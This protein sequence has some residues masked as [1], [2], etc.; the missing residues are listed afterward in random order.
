MERRRL[1]LKEEHGALAGLY[2]GSSDEGIG[3]VLSLYS[4][5]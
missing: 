3:L 4:K 2:G 1:S 5:G